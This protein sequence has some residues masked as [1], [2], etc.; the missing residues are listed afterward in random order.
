VAPGTL[1]PVGNTLVSVAAVEGIA[2]AVETVLKLDAATPIADAFR[3]VRRTETG[4]ALKGT[5]ET[6]FRTTFGIDF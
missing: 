4:S 5:F 1:R 2:W 3:A 6:A